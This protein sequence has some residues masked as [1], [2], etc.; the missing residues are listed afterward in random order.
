MV[1]PHEKIRS[2]KVSVLEEISMSMSVAQQLCVPLALVSV[3]PESSQMP[4][5][6]FIGG[7]GGAS[8]GA[9]GGFVG[10]SVPPAESE[11]EWPSGTTNTGESVLP[12]STEGPG[13]VLEL[14]PHAHTAKNNPSAITFLTMLDPLA[15]VRRARA[16]HDAK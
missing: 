1:F 13:G 11:G 12:P 10:A 16:P 2:P 9:S 3:M 4:L 7:G 5:E 15:S 14:E 8:G 6:R